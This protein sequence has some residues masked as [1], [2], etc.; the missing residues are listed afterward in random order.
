MIIAEITGGLGNQMFQ[1]AKGRAVAKALGT[2]LK[3]DIHSYHWDKLRTYGLEV[4]NLE[5]PFADR[6]EIDL[7]QGKIKERQSRWKPWLPGLKK[8]PAFGIWQEASFA[9][10]EK[11]LQIPDGKYLRGYWQSPRHFENI[12]SIIRQDFS[13]KFPPPKEVGKVIEQMR[14]GDSVALH[15]RR[16][17]YALNQSTQAF[18]GLCS[19]EYFK[20]GMAYMREQL[21]NPLFFVFSD[22]P[23]WARACFSEE[24]NLA[25]V[26]LSVPDYEDL[27]MMQ[28][29]QHQII[30]NSTFSW[31]AAWLNPNPN[32]RVVAPEPWFEDPNIQSQSQ[33]LYL[34]HWKR[35]P[36]H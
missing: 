11:D 16:G 12:Q 33:S 5:V 31:W 36:K 34:E 4:F 28:H 26:A 10:S 17:D 1:Y 6:G 2:A 7:Q 9:F 8:T 3:L 20:K 30:S 24:P 23:E 14:L 21:T 18:H 13:F 15:V 27:R 35:L 25:V 19:P 29:A 32:K 22:D